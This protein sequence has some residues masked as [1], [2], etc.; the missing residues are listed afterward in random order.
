MATC[1]L[2]A[3]GIISGFLAQGVLGFKAAQ[4]GVYLHGL[5]GEIVSNDI[6]LHSLLARDLCDNI[7]RG[8]LELEKYY[9]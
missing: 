5:I 1:E 2:S 7:A 6:G 3:S 8:L 9:E 4:L